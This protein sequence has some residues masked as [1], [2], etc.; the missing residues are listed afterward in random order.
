ML[1]AL[2]GRHAD[3]RAVREIVLQKIGRTRFYHH[4]T[5]TFAR[6]AALAGDSEEAARWL[7]ETI[8]WGFPCYPMFSTDSFLD[9]V[10]HTPR[11]QAVLAKLK[12]DW[13][14]YR[15]ALQ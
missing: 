6:M 10:R 4:V 15:A 9:P 12:T 2:Q 7:E 14:G 3:A 11:V 1:R 5:Y 13:D 8:A